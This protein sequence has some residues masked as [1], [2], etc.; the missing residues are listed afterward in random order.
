MFYINENIPCKT[1]IAEDLPD[2]C[3]IT[4]IESSIKSRKWLTV[5]L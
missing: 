4:L 3:E 2:D 1:V 5:G